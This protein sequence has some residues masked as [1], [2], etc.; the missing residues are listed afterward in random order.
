M[1]LSRGSAFFFFFLFLPLQPVKV[2]AINRR[3]RRYVI[4]TIA[5]LYR[6]ARARESLR[7]I[8]SRARP[9]RYEILQYVPRSLYAAD[10]TRVATAE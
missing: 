5:T 3:A 7:I 10:N 4:A 1:E 9:A 6:C 8:I 2:Y